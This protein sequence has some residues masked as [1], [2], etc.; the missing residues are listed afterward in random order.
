MTMTGYTETERQVLTR[1]QRGIELCERPF[2]D[3]PLAAAELLELLAR[4]RSDGL[5]RRFGAVF[6]ARR[7]G[8]RSVLCALDTPAERIEAKAQIVAAEDGVTHCY[9]RRPLLGGGD[10]PALWFTL[11]LLHDEF[12]AGLA[13]LRGRLEDADSRLLELPA[14]R[15]FKIDV[16]F[17]LRTRARDE[18]FPGAAAAA[19]FARAE[20][21]RAFSERDRNIVRAMDQNVPLAEQ[22]FMQLAEQLGIGHRE[23]LEIL[24]EWK[25]AGLLRR[26]AAVLRHREAGFK[27]NGMCVWPASGDIVEIGRRVA[28]QPEVTHCYQRPRSAVMPFDLYAM[29][30]RGD[31]DATRALFDDISARCGLRDG[32]M[33]ASLR[34]FKKSSMQYFK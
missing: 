1:L 13:R 21:F 33:F 15:R 31:W 32:E 12:S 26:V 9:E 3:F 19:E 23:L 25:A 18:R 30:H 8:Y 24:R 20:D 4:A 11:A 22:P 14:L 16:V 28:A 5:L 27:A 10:Y 7:L 29:I 34:E 2:A 6:D 17:D